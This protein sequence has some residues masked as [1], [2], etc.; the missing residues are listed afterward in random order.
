VRRLFTFLGLFIFLVFFVAMIFL[1]FG[2]SNENAPLQSEQ[3]YYFR[4]NLLDRP[5][6]RRD[7]D[8][9]G[10]S[11]NQGS[12]AALVNL[13]RFVHLLGFLRGHARPPLHAPKSNGMRAPRPLV[14]FGSQL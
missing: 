9:N 1:L 6:Q 8:L 14:Q 5:R 4:A 11:A 3:S 7:F 12:R 13:R 10:R 2:G